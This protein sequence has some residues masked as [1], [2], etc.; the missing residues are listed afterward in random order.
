MAATGIFPASVFV[1]FVVFFPGKEIQAWGC[2]DEI[3]MM[4]KGFRFVKIVVSNFDTPSPVF[5]RG[6]E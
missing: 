2:K 3:K 4:K 5:P 1:W 6:R